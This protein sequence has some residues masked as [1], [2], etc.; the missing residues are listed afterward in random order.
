MRSGVYAFQRVARFSVLNQKKLDP[1]Q[2][3]LKEPS[4]NIKIPNYLIY[5]FSLKP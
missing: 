1:N 4:S 2:R 5:D 3:T